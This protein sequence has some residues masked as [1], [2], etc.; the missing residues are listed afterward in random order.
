MSSVINTIRR[1]PSTAAVTL[2]IAITISVALAAAPARA[3]ARI[4]FPEAAP[5]IRDCV[6]GRF[7][8]F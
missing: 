2:L 3:V 1:Q 5:V 7:A 4:G 8:Q 6:E